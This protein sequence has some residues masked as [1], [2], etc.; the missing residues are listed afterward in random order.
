MFIGAFNAVF[1]KIKNNP[2]R[3]TKYELIFYYSG[4]SDEDGI[5]LSDDKI[6]FVD[7]KKA[8]ESIPADVRIA[9]LDSCYSGAFTHAQGRTEET[10]VHD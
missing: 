1:T 4:H 2:D 8:V 5:L 7:L 3:N 10:A 9:I 6:P